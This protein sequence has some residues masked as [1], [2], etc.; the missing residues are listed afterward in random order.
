MA[1]KTLPKQPTDTQPEQGLENALTGLTSSTVST[2]KKFRMH[3]VVVVACV[4]LCVVGYTAWTALAQERLEQVSARLSRVTD[5]DA[6]EPLSLTAIDEL[7]ADVEGTKPE[8]YVVKTIGS[9]LAEL[10]MADTGDDPQAK[11]RLEPTQA[12]EKALALARSAA[13]R[14][15]GDADMKTWALNVEKV[16]TAKDSSEWMP[17]SATFELPVPNEASSEN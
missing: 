13:E 3:I 9:F 16:L 11:P 7:L 2:I 10:A 4:L 15:A 1:R 17:P 8:P 6:T 14:F 5:P 12:K